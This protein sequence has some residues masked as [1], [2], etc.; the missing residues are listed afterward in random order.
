MVEEALDE[1]R[2]VL[3]DELGVPGLSTRWWAV[4]E[5]AEEERS[6]VESLGVSRE[7]SDL[8]RGLSQARGRGVLEQ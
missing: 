3:L 5:L 8:S 7:V 4:K 2:Q 6:M 1:L